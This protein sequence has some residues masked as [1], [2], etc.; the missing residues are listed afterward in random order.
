MS[1]PTPS[2][3]SA[4]RCFVVPCSAV[5]TPT[6]TCMW[7]E[8]ASTRMNHVCTPESGRRGTD[9]RLMP[10]PLDACTSWRPPMAM[11]ICGELVDPSPLASKRSMGTETTLALGAPP[12][13]LT[14]ASTPSASLGVSG[15]GTM[16]A[17]SG[18]T[19]ETQRNAS[20]SIALRAAASLARVSS[21]STHATGS[22]LAALV[23]SLRDAL[24]AASVA[25]LSSS[26]T[27]EIRAPSRPAGTSLAT[28][29][30]ADR[31][32]AASAASTRGSLVSHLKNP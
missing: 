27:R 7:L 13:S 14:A 2:P 18:E 17:S 5:A 23:F 10:Q 1:T 22:A 32:D 21:S 31:A 16:P 24:M 29:A 26:S 15:G 4:P 28:A 6:K 25:L 3:A 19:T 9:A 11:R 8:E 20:T 30:S 12:E